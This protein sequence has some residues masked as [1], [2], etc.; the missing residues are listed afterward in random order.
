MAAKKSTGKAK[1]STPRVLVN[2][3]GGGK[4]NEGKNPKTVWV[5]KKVADALGLKPSLSPR[6]TKKTAG[7]QDIFLKGSLYAGSMKVI[8]GNK[9][10]SVPVPADA[11]IS[12]MV[13]FA[14]R[15]KA[16]K[17]VSPGGTSYAVSTGSK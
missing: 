11:T 9:G 14:K 3:S 12:D 2:F 15:C 17:I 16:D 6:S 8:K 5:T 13:A 4:K 1:K 10:Y 7:G